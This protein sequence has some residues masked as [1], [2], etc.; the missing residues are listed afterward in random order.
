[1]KKFL[2]TLWH[3]VLLVAAV[4]YAVSCSLTV[5]PSGA[6]SFHLDGTQT[7][8]AIEIFSAK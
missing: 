1:M 3:L 6:K 7:L 8:R 5:E 2:L 4:L